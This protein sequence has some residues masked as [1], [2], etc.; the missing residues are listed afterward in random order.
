MKLL[1][2]NIRL[3]DNNKKTDKLTLICLLII[4][5]LF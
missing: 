4:T 2:V 3:S 1:P 5:I